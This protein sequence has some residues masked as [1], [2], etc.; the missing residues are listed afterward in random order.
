MIHNVGN[1]H[2]YL[3]YIVVN[4]CQ[5]VYVDSKKL[6][7]NLMSPFFID[8]KVTPHYLY[9]RTCQYSLIIS[10]S[11]MRWFYIGRLL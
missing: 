10:Q 7:D 3:I 8:V 6:K 1:V 2:V 4:P 5:C 11:N 9:I